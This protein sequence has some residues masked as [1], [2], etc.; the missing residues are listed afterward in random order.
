[1]NHIP[2]LIYIKSLHISQLAENCSEFIDGI[3]GQ[4]QS[5]R[6]RLAAAFPNCIHRGQ[7][8]TYSE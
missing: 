8:V 3:P 7:Q 2:G 5:F 4:R 1:M 6:K